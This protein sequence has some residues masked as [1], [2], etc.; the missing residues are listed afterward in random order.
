[1]MDRVG[2]VII[3]TEIRLREMVQN[4]LR[5]RAISIPR[6]I[7]VK[8]SEFAKLNSPSFLSRDGQSKF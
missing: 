3:R 7:M 1:M 6:L 2:V 8:A 5:D 4:A